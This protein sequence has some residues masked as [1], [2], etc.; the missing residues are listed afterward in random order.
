MKQNTDL[1]GNVCSE[2]TTHEISLTPWQEGK[3]IR[4]YVIA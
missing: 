3:G 2:N 1:F 4:I